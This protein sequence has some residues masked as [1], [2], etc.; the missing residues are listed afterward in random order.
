MSEISNNLNAI[1]NNLL[2]EVTNA[3]NQDAKVG[4]T[5]TMENGGI[6]NISYTNQG[7]K[8]IGGKDTKEQ[9]MAALLSQDPEV[10]G[11]MVSELCSSLSTDALQSTAKAS[12]GV[13]NDL[14]VC[15]KNSVETTDT[16]TNTPEVSNGLDG[17]MGKLSSFDIRDLMKLLIKA[18][19]QFFQ[20]QRAIDLSNIEQIQAAMEA[21]IDA[22]EDEKEASY[23]AALSQAIG[24]IVSGAI[25]VG[26]GLF[27]I[28]GGLADI[29]GGYFSGKE[30]S[31]ADKLLKGSGTVGNN[32]LTKTDK[33]QVQQ[34]QQQAD[35]IMNRWH[36]GA[37]IANGLGQAINGLGG[38]ASGTAGIFSAAYTSDAK[39][40]QIQ[41]TTQDA[42]LE[43]LKKMQN[44]GS[45]QTKQLMD[46]IARILSMIQELQ[47]AAAQTEKTIV[48]A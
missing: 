11:K 3:Q 6:T 2:S 10:T 12:M 40:A 19:A 46:F 26:A 45:E 48:Q 15:A 28:A 7:G 34:I 32:T 24:S 14:V 21:K 44:D 37:T 13:I 5:K 31:K 16:K 8:S 47:Q 22:M 39:D 30:L 43:I 29:G 18:F 1:Q 33:V 42:V 41:Q 36:G 9:A 20:T 25:S 23:S 17:L 4:L 27:S 38:I 35:H